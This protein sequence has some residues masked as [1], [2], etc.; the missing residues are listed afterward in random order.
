[1]SIIEDAAMS[2]IPGVGQARLIWEA[3]KKLLPAF[4]IIAI[5]VYAAVQHGEAVHFHKKADSLLAW[6]VTVSQ[7]VTDAAI[8]GQAKKPLAPADV[9]PQVKAMGLSIASLRASLDGQNAA[10]TAL[11][12]KSDAQQVAAQAAIKRARSANAATEAAAAH[13][14]AGAHAGGCNASATYALVRKDL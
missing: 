14:V 3:A 13:L 9:V 11:G 1:M 10:V 4:G 2:A 7:A 5:A 8:G 6:Q 12:E